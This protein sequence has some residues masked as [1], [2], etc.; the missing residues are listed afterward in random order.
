MTCNF[1]DFA[2][3]RVILQAI[4]ILQALFDQVGDF[5]VGPEGPSPPIVFVSMNLS[6]IY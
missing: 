6:L 1:R 3:D 2:S 4:V 5:H